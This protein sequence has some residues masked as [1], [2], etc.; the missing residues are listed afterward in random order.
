MCARSL[1]SLA[2]ASS[3]SSCGRHR[4]P[5]KRAVSTSASW[6]PKHAYFLTYSAS[7]TSNFCSGPKGSSKYHVPALQYFWRVRLAANLLKKRECACDNVKTLTNQVPILTTSQRRIRVQRPLIPVAAW[8]NLAVGVVWVARVSSERARALVVSRFSTTTECVQIH[9]CPPRA[10]RNKG[11][12]KRQNP[13][14]TLV[15]LHHHSA[16]MFTQ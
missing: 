12:R 7:T 2:P 15:C 3:A 4:H 11:S 6:R 13:L 9:D 10:P 8:R 16:C 1:L 14:Q 5:Q